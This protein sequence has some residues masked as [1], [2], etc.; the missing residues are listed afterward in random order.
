MTEFPAH[1]SRTVWVTSIAVI[2]LMLTIAASGLV[3]ELPD[4]GGFMLFHLTILPLV[5]LAVATPF[6]VRGYALRGTTL[7][8][9]RLG[10][11]ESIDLTGL[12]AARVAP[13]G[14]RRSWRVFGSGGYWGYVGQFRRRDLGMF[15]ALATRSEPGVFLTLRGGGVL[16]VSP[17][18]PE[19]LVAA[20]A[21]LIEA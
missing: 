20:V 11:R 6:G 17:D 21:P 19:A 1:W 10:W 3:I 12:R 15:R 4:A 2:G 5:V 8:V 16:F 9:L 14:M 13:D 18:D 7:H